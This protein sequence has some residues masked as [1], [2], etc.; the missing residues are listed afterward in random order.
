MEL[1]WK[2]RKTANTG[3]ASPAS[4]RTT[5]DVVAVLAAFGAV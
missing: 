3:K 2:V 4:I 1:V 5:Y